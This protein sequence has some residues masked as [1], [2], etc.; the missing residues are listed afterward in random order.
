MITAVNAFNYIANTTD[1]RT[2]HTA[3]QNTKHLYI[4]IYNL[5]LSNNNI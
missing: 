5:Y 4:H 1:S 3:L 2:K